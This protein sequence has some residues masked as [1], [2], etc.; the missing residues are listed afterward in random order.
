MV[1]RNEITYCLLLSGRYQVGANRTQQLGEI[2][3][4]ANALGNTRDMLTNS[5]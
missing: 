2:E 5:R 4:E 3:L 1:I